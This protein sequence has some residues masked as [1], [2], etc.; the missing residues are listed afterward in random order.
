MMP[1]LHHAD[2]RF[3]VSTHSDELSVV[4]CLR[5]LADFN[6]KIGNKRIAWS[7]TT[8]DHWRRNAHTVTFRFS[9]P[10]YREDFLSEAKRLL[11]N[12]LWAV[13][14][15]RDDDPAQPRQR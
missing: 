12:N 7:G 6:Q 1:T 10:Q 2:Y 11:P 3:S 13:V 14:G 5:A 9:D 8:D 4:G 15:T